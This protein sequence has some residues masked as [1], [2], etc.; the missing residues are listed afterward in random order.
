[1]LWHRQMSLDPR[2]PTLDMASLTWHSWQRQGGLMIAPSLAHTPH[3]HFV[4]LNTPM[5]NDTVLRTLIAG[6]EMS[7]LSSCLWGLLSS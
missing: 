7:S 4:H 6:G 2:L 5:Y 1:M 3:A